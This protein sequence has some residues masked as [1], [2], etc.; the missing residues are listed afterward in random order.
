M[1][2]ILLKI[3]YLSLRNSIDYRIEVLSG[4]HQKRM[5]QQEEEMENNKNLHAMQPI[6]WL[7]QQQ[8]QRH[9]YKTW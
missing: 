2:L 3:C 6:R 7:G 1:Y 4:R 8:D 9:G 5:L